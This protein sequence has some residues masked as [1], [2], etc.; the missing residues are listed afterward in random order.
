MVMSKRSVQILTLEWPFD[1]ITVH[2]VA[3]TNIVEELNSVDQ[4]ENQHFSSVL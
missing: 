2:E 3:A 4:R 1:T